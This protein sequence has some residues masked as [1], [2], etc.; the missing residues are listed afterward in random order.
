MTNFSSLRAL[1]IVA[2]LAALAVP[3]AAQDIPRNIPD[4]PTESPADRQREELRERNR[5]AISKFF[6]G[7]SFAVAPALGRYSSAMSYQL[8]VGFDRRGA[9]AIYLT[10]GARRY[11]TLGADQFGLTDEA[12][13]LFML[14]YDLGLDR[15]TGDERF[16]RAAVGIG[17][18]GVYGGD[19]G[20]MTVDV[21]PKYTI[22]INRYW[23]LPVGLRFGQTILGNFEEGVR[24]TFIGASIGLKLHFGHRP[25]FK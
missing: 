22:P 1:C 16:D 6:L 19:A 18:G 20:R 3:V 15:F 25:Y 4:D 10:L 5:E 13:G 9:S 12:A 24:T 2:L 8:E 17:V 21:A 14:G 23:S 7:N 11:A